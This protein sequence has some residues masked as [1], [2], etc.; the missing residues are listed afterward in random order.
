MTQRLGVPGGLDVFQYLANDA[1][2]WGQSVAFP[3]TIIYAK[4][5]AEALVLYAKAIGEKGLNEPY[6]I[7]W[8]SDN[9]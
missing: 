4:S 5:M 2:D 6:S 9:E 3:E 7:R 8:M 1:T